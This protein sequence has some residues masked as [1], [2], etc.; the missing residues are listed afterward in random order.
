[1]RPTKDAIK[2]LGKLFYNIALLVIGAVIIHPAVGGK[3]TLGLLFWGFLG[4]V[5]FVILGL[6]LISLGDKLEN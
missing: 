4:F 6:T 2:E 1:M 5:V 3:L